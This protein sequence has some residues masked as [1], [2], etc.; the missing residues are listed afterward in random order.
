MGWKPMP[1][2]FLRRPNE[3]GPSGHSAEKKY[4]NRIGRYGQFWLLSNARPCGCGPS[5]W[6]PET[7]SDTSFEKITP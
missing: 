7:L 6:E 4:V 3:N 1:P 2:L 5:A